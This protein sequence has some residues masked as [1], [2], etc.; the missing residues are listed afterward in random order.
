MAAG[1][2]IPRSWDELW[3]PGRIAPMLA[4]RAQEPFSSPAFRFEIKW[5]GYRC[6][7]F[8]DPRSGTTFLQS[9]HGY[10][11]TPFFPELA[12]LHRLLAAPAVLDGEIVALAGGLPS[13][14]ALQR[15]LGRPA[16]TRRPP[17]PVPAL[18]VIFDLL[19]D[20]GRVRLG[21]PLAE[22]LQR[23]ARLFPG[24]AAP[25]L[26]LSQGVVEAGEALFAR[27][28]AQGLEGV[29][30]KRLD[31]PY[32]P[33][34]RT[35]YW[36]KIK[37][38][39]ELEAVV[40]GVVPGGRAAGVGTLLL[41]LFGPGDALHY[42]GHVSTGLGSGEAR[43]L[44]ARL[45]PR[46][47]C[48]FARIPERARGQPVVWAEPALVC[49]VGYLEWT[50]QGHLRHPVFRRWRD[51]VPASR[52]RLPGS[53]PARAAA[54]LEHPP[55]AAAG[56]GPAGGDGQGEA[57]GRGDGDGGGSPAPGSRPRDGDRPG[58]GN[59]PRAADSPGQGA[60]RQAVGPS[61]AAGAAGAP[62]GGEGPRPG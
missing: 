31:S 58:Y 28:R 15:R 60:D 42:V 13:F 49:Q 55:A 3:Q 26:V 1:P 14:A 56:H 46:A 39:R 41:G 24:G 17:G 45:R 23:L 34:W 8:A 12:V 27:V 62:R 50:P 11:L 40:G 36:Q 51:D 10:D 30:A 43:W 38:E 5:D 52:C 59:R 22:R 32:L 19:G 48:P 44:L 2:P 37:A 29:V 54:G 33:G 18:L 7:V 47:T 35:A 57:G 4:R 6:L 61:A 25:G 16:G 53:H 20:G 21:E 9:R